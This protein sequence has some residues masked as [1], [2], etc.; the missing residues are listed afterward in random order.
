MA[1]KPKAATAANKPADEKIE[2]ESIK[3]VKAN[4]AKPVKQVKKSDPNYD[5]KIDGEID[6]DKVI[7][8][9]KAIEAELAKLS[10]TDKVAFLRAAFD[11]YGIN[12]DGQKILMAEMAAIKQN[13][14]VGGDL[15]L[16][17]SQ[18]WDKL[19]W[20]PIV[21][22][23]YRIDATYPLS[24]LFPIKEV[25]NGTELIFY[26]DFKDADDLPAYKLPDDYVGKLYNADESISVEEQ[27]SVYQDIHKGLKMPSI[28]LNDFTSNEAIFLSLMSNIAYQVAR[29]IAKV[30]YKKRLQLVQDASQI[31]EKLDWTGI[32]TDYTIEKSDEYQTLTELKNLF[33]TLSQVSRNLPDR[34]RPNGLTQNLEIALNMSDYVAV[35]PN[36][37]KNM[38]DVEMKSGRFNEKYLNV[39]P[40]ILALNFK[41][42]FGDYIGAT[43]I[44]DSRTDMQIFLVPKAKHHIIQQYDGSRAQPLLTFHDVIH[45]YMRIGHDFNK[46]YPIISINVKITK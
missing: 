9:T 21:Q 3:T 37:F 26:N 25:K 30:L 28:M 19:G 39:M 13:A 35:V 36:D 38:L 34:W 8:D 10:E 22:M 32:T 11:K 7:A 27:W 31:K 33:D 23:L 17:Q 20:L 14:I 42:S 16:P 44:K 40:E 18:F 24:N 46:N 6:R 5:T 15:K 4:K 29:P 2:A 1:N 43:N 12:A 45:R 41:S